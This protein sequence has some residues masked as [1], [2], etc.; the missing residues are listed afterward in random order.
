VSTD[1]PARCFLLRSQGGVAGW[2][3][4]LRSRCVIEGRGAAARGRGEGG[5][6]SEHGVREVGESAARRDR[7]HVWKNGRRRVHVCSA[8]HVMCRMLSRYGCQAFH[9]EVSHRID[10]RTSA[11]GVAR[12]GRASRI[13]TMYDRWASSLFI[14]RR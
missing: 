2:P 11:T 3:G 8:P 10:A 13:S 14:P 1:W 5:E 12:V 9:G 4:D 6:G 7:V